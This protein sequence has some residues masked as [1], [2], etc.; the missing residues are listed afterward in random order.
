MKKVTKAIFP[1]AG[2]GTRFLPA[3]KAMPKEM[4]TVV[5]KPL[6]QYAVEEALSAG[7][8]D[9][10]F[11]TGRGKDTIENHF[12]YSYELADTLK[13]KSKLDILEI[14]NNIIPS[15]CRIYYTRQGEPL[16]LGHAVNCA[17]HIIDDEPVAVLLPD[18]MIYAED[19]VPLK[20]MIAAYEKSGK[21]IIM[22]EEVPMEK[23]SN[24]GVLDLNGT[25]VKNGL[26]NV[27]GFVEKPAV[28][29]APSNLA[30]IGRYIITPKTFE[31]LAQKNIGAGGEIQLT[32]ALHKICQEEGAL[33]YVLRAYR[34][35]CG[36]KVGF[37][38]ANLFFAMQD[39][40]L[41]EKLLPFVQKI[42]EKYNR[43][44]TPRLVEGS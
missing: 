10:I 35:D 28:E 7:I 22:A 27:S 5:D 29:D 23:V 11:V 12:D 44:E 17:A 6:I 37:Q 15:H 4:L 16:G 18:D 30:I 21:S 36:S 3:T 20:E 43:R 32:D 40:K 38:Q 2:L 41:A 14:V 34:F 42:A 39:E 25:G 24:Y 31:H 33:G 19:Y 26:A 9:F 8:T 1:V 13:K